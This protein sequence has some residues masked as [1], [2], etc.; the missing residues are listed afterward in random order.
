[1]PFAEIEGG[2]YPEEEGN[3]GVVLMPPF[4]LLD[5]D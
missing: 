2:E 3:V 1:M 4:E 5:M